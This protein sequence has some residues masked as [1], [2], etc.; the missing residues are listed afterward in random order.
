MIN[1]LVK[2]MAVLGLT[3]IICIGGFGCMTVNNKKEILE[4]MEKKYNEE[5]VVESYT[6]WNKL[7]NQYGGGKIIAHPKGN[8]DLVF[9]AGVLDS[10]NGGYYEN[11]QETIYGVELKKYFKDSIT[12]NMSNPFDFAIYF[13][14][15]D[16]DNTKE[17]QEM[18]LEE[19]LEYG[20]EE[21]GIVMDLGIEVGSEDEI[22]KHYE[23]VLNIYNLLKD[24]KVDKFTLNVGFVKDINSSNIKSYFIKSEVYN[25][26]WDDLGSEVYGK[27]VV[28]R[29]SNIENINEINNKYRSFTN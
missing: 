13:D 16:L 4:Y 23:E 10:K 14:F 20:K 24:F 2:M 19:I 27:I 3:A 26:T 28:N 21:V 17:A 6:P 5:F 1:K 25:N 15:G 9:Y 8:P 7:T 11:Y 22:S 29:K 12:S 18:N